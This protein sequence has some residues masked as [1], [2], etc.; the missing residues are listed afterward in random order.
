M[1]HTPAASRLHMAAVFLWGESRVPHVGRGQLPYPARSHQVL[2]LC[3]PHAASLRHLKASPP[4]HNHRGAVHTRACPLQLGPGCRILPPFCL[5]RRPCPSFS[6]R[7]DFS[8]SLLLSWSPSSLDAL[9]R[10]YIPMFS[11]SRADYRPQN[12]QRKG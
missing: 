7:A 6:Y 2:A 12:D 9:F 4:L 10:D 11:S 3:A 1:V 8:S 5:H